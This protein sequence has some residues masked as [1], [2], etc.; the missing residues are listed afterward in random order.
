MGMCGRGPLPLLWHSFS[1]SLEIRGFF[2][3]AAGAEEVLPGMVAR[4]LKIE[5]L[6]CLYISCTCIFLCLYYLSRLFL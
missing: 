1:P 5:S 6:D 4:S 2:N 3:E